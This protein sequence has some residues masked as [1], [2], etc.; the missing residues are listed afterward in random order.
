VVQ[1]VCARGRPCWEALSSPHGG[2]QA[3]RG[4]SQLTPPP[5]PPAERLSGRAVRAGGRAWCAP[6]PAPRYRAA[7]P[8]AARSKIGVQLSGPARRS[9][10]VPMRSDRPQC[11]CWLRVRTA[12]M[13]LAALLLSSL[14]CTTSAPE[15]LRLTVKRRPRC[16]HGVSKRATHAWPARR[17]HSTMRRASV[18][19]RAL[20]ARRVLR[21]LRALGQRPVPHPRGAARAHVRQRA[22]SHVRAADAVAAQHHAARQVHLPVR[23]RACQ[24][25]CLHGRQTALFR[26]VAGSSAWA[27][28]GAS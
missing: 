5:R 2:R 27:G 23:P 21:H 13:R 1:R 4:G 19:Y 9:C 15:S 22:R 3:Q 28:C 24:P 8:R 17:S 25:R 12:L 10:S 26:V 20:R 11:A 16:K 18:P 14:T 7:R 6:R